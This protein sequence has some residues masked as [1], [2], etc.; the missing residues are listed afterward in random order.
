MNAPDGRSTRGPSGCSTRGPD[1][2]CPRGGRGRRPAGGGTPGVIAL[3]ARQPR[4]HDRY[5]FALC[6]VEPCRSA[7]IERRL[8]EEEDPAV[9]RGARHQMVRPLVDEIP[10]KVRKAQKV[11][12]QRRLLERD[13]SGYRAYPGRPPSSAVVGNGCRRAIAVRHI[14]RL[15]KVRR[16]VP[17]GTEV[18]I[19]LAI[20]T[21]REALHLP[22]LCKPATGCPG[23]VRNCWAE[24]SEQRL[25]RSVSLSRPVTRWRRGR[26][27]RCGQRRPRRTPWPLDDSCDRRSHSS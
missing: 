27:T 1:P 12:R 18:A 10:A 15:S 22:H 19:Q 5:A 3:G 16:S 6:Q 9:T 7:L 24:Y 25:Y 13:A 21:G 23:T 11:T 20:P 14:R 17:T 4:C 26:S 8:F 2:R